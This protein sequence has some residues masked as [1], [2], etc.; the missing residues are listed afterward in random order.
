MVIADEL[1]PILIIM[2]CR[3]FGN[4]LDLNC[5]IILLPVCRTFVRYFYDL[6]TQSQAMS[7]RF[8]RSIL[9]MIPLDKAIHFHECLGWAILVFSGG[10]TF[11]HILNY[12]SAPDVTVAIFGWWPFISGPLIFLCMLFMYGAVPSGVKRYHFEIFWYSHQLFWLF[13]ILL[14]TH[15]A[16]GWNPNVFKWLAVPGAIYLAERLYRYKSAYRDVA[17]TGASVMDK[18]L[19]LEFDRD[20]AFPNVRKLV[21]R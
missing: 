20:R 15:G 14:L 17:V 4:L 1:N 19:I 3:V 9:K 10:H 12:G 11:F 8:L 5:G 7:Q 13:F 18:V 16:G 21:P 2:F 6:S